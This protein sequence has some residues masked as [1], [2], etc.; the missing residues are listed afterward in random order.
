MRRSGQTTREIDA[1]I[2]E[3]FTKGKIVVGDHHGTRE[4]DRHQFMGILGRMAHEHP[5]EELIVDRNRFSIKMAQRSIL[6]LIRPYQEV[7]SHCNNEI[8]K[9]ISTV[10][11][12][13]HF[14]DNKDRAKFFY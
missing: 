6:E 9:I 7:I 11:H 3:L 2:Q 14:F 10:S 1:A 8:N 12:P 4:A 5:N 13:R